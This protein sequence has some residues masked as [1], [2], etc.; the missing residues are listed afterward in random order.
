VNRL[1]GATQA[2]ADGMRAKAEVV[3]GEIARMALGTRV[4][5]K[6]GWVNAP[7]LRDALKSCD[8][9][10]CCTDDHAGRVFL[11]R[12]AYFYLIPVFDMGL[13]M[14]VAKPPATGMADISARVTTIRTP[15][16]ITAP[17][18]D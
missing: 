6:R 17:I 13:A 11:N 2:D 3:G 4:I 18:S 12:L 16:K 8:V 1:H 9:I 5:A 14:A 10:F 15:A 7:Q